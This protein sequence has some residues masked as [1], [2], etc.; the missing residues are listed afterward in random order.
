M[1]NNFFQN[2]FATIERNVVKGDRT[3]NRKTE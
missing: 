2:I 1:K 3:I